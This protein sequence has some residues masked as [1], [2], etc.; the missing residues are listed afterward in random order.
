VQLVLDFVET[1]DAETRLS[2]VWE[3]LEPEQR[4]ALVTTLARLMAKAV[5][6]MEDD[7]E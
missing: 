7:D 6:P 3:G 5:D 2:V 4:G 1:N